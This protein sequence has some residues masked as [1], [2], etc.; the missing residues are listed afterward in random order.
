MEIFKVTKFI[1]I[2]LG[3][4]IMLMTAADVNADDEDILI[5]TK[6]GCSHCAK[7]MDYVEKHDLQDKVTERNVTFDDGAADEYTK[8]LEDHDI[9]LEESGTPMMVH[10]GDNWILGDIPIMEFLQGKFDIEEEEDEEAFS[11]GDYVIMGGGVLFV[12]FVLGY[13]ILS[14]VN[15]RRKN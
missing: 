8:F 4:G 14:I 2:F 12:C 7:V 3:I 5:Y 9:P 13:G 10:G 1:M 11:A 15:G 6:E